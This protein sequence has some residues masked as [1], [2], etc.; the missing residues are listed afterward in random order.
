M[1]SR[2]CAAPSTHSQKTNEELTK[3]EKSVFFI[4]LSTTNEIL[5]ISTRIFYSSLE[6]TTAQNYEEKKEEEKVKIYF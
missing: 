3:K 4:S 5:G 1:V 2:G 6:R